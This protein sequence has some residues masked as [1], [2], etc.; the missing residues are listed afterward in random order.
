[1]AAAQPPHLQRIVVL[2]VMRIDRFKSTDL[3]RLLL[4]IAK[5]QRS[6]HGKMG[7]VLARIGPAPICLTRVRFEHRLV[8][9][10]SRSFLTSITFR[11]EQT[12]AY[13]LTYFAKKIKYTS[14]LEG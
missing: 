4:Q 12:D 10:V 14:N 5:L 1:M 2:V 13:P 11:A 8:P 3:A 9:H 7:T 6:L